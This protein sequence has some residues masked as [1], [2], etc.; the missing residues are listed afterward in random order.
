VT[1]R[2]RLR[3]L[4]ID[5]S[6]FS[7]RTIIGMLERSPLVE[8]ADWAP[9]GQ[10]ALAK[11]LEHPYDVITLDLEMPRMDGFTFLRMLMARRPTPVIVVSGRGDSQDVFK[12]LEL[13]AVDF[14]AKPTPRAT[15]ELAT[16]E[17]ELIR[18][19]HGIREL[20]LD[21]VVRQPLAE[22][23]PRARSALRPHRVV[24]IG[25]STGGPAALLRLFAG[26][27]TPPPCAFV[28]AQHMP[29]GFTASFAR[30]L[31]A[32]TCLRAHEAQE[33]ALVE[34]GTILVAAGGSH[35]EFEAEGAAVVARLASRSAHERYAPSVDR[36]FRSAAKHWGGDLLALVLTGMGDDG[37]AGASAVKRAGG[38]VIVESAETAVIYGM[39]QQ[40]IRA[41]AVDAVVPLHE[42]AA[43]IE[44]GFAG[45]RPAQPRGGA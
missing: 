44:S 30:R 6:A 39:P 45:P 20:R 41:G 18:K 14:V 2:P 32:T 25:S 9:D 27:A 21:R 16:I 31:D 38:N 12:A 42:I 13:G 28:V 22:A 40:A 5:D 1:E 43:L 10:E 23:P 3:A 11:A 35:L 19:V 34:E 17:Q 15:P 7:R 37:A 24:A 29:A 33:G 4:V 36:M 26:F 8:Q